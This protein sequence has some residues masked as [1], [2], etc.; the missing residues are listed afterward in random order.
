MAFNREEWF[1][2]A[3]KKLVPLFVINNAEI[4]EQL[5][6][7]V[8]RTTGRSSA[9]TTTIGETWHCTNEDKSIV[10][11]FISPTL[12]DTIEVLSVLT[13]ELVH[14]CLGKGEGSTGHGNDFKELAGGVGMV[15]PWTQPIPS[16]NLQEYFV[17]NII[18]SIGQYGQPEFQFGQPAEKKAGTR[19]MKIVCPDCGY[20]VRTTYKWIATGLPFCGNMDCDRPRMEMA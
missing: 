17:D 1:N 12:T 3:K 6:I 19:L 11:I 16:E 4:P 14:A 9:T 15:A 20:I 18:A 2:L 13:H 10:H 7:S 8:G 5:Y